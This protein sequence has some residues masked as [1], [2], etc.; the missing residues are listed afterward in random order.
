MAEL[1][2]NIGPT[3][4]YFEDEP[5]FELGWS[6]E[7][8]VKPPKPTTFLQFPKTNSSQLWGGYGRDIVSSNM[9]QGGPGLPNMGILA[10]KWFTQ[11]SERN[12]YKPIVLAHKAPAAGEPDPYYCFDYWPVP[13]TYQTNLFQSE[14]WDRS[15]RAMGARATQFGPLS[16]GMRLLAEDREA[17]ENYQIILQPAMRIEENL[18]QHVI[19]DGMTESEKAGWEFENK[20]RSQAL[21]IF[22]SIATGSETEPLAVPPNQPK[23]PGT[24]AQG[25]QVEDEGIPDCPRWT[26]ILNY[27]LNNRGPLELALDSLTFEIPEPTL[28]RYI[29]NRG[30]LD[31]SP[32]EWRAFL[33]TANHKGEYFR[34]VPF[35]PS[36]SVQTK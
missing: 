21:L 3:E 25:V 32:T 13:V 29:L 4:P 33:R 10:T 17:P 30:G 31:I 12:L 28:Y 23:D 22:Y 7:D 36:P 20:R 8:K 27:L 35:P 18:T 1:L 26:E 15:V 11:K 14:F 34:Y 19:H 24:E 5:L 6:L 2:P 16:V 9:W